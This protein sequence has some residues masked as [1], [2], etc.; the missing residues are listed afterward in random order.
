MRTF[1]QELPAW[2]LYLTGWAHSLYHRA[3]KLQHFGATSNPGTVDLMSAIY[4]SHCDYFVTADAGQRRAL[5]VLNMFNTRLPRTQVISYQE[6]RRRLVIHC[7]PACIL[8]I[9]AATP[10]RF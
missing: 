10:F 5:R 8:S 2:P 6:F 4:L 1:C 3:L 7:T 9:P